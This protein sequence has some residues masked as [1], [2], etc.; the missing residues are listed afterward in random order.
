MCQL[1]SYGGHDKLREEICDGCAKKTVSM[2]YKSVDS[3]FSQFSRDWRPIVAAF[4]EDKREIYNHFKF[5]L[6]VG[7]STVAAGSSRGSDSSTPL[8]DHGDSLFHADKEW[9]SIDFD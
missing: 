2:Q 5:N 7:A 8:A 4:H 9:R 6:H 3:T 1:G